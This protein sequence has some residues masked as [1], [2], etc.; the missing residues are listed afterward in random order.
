MKF[1]SQLSPDTSLRE[2]DRR[3]FLAWTASAALVGTIPRTSRAESNVDRI[4]VLTF[5]DAVKT[6]RTTVAPLLRELG[7]G[8]S[9]FVCHRWMVPGPDAY[10]DPDQYMTW[11]DIAELHQMGFEIGNHSWTHPSFSVP[12]DAAR[13]PA[14]LALV[15]FEL[16]KVGVP[17]PTSFA[18]CGDAFC[19]EAVQNL[20]DLGYKVAR[21]G[22]EPEVPFG[23]LTRTGPTYDPQ[24]QNPFL[25]PT[26][27]NN[28]PG[29][30]MDHFQ[31][32]ADQ[33]HPGQIVVYQFHGVPDPHPWVNCPP[34]RF[35]GYMQ[36]LKQAGFRVV[37]LKDVEQYLPTTFPADRVLK[38]PYLGS[39]AMK[40][41]LPTEMEATRADLEYWLTNMVHYHRYTWDE[42]EKVTGLPRDVLKARTRAI[43]TVG[44]SS[45]EA[46]G[47]EKPIRALP[48]PGGRHP[49]IGALEEAI[50]PLRGTKA[51][52]F[53]PWDPVS[54]VV[55]DLPEAISS[56]SGLI[57]QAHTYAPTI[58]D[59]QNIWLENIDWG[60]TPPGSLSTN[61][62]LPNKIAFGGLV[63][64]S[65]GAVDLELWLRN[66]S[67]EKLSSLSTRISLLLKGASDFDGLTN[68]NKVFQNPVSAVAS[69]RRDRW[70]LLAWDRSGRTW[71]DSRIPCIY[72]EVVLP[73]CNAG[74]VVRTHGRLWFYEG[75]DVT[76]EINRARQI[77]S[78]TTLSG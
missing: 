55:I 9:F 44:S 62:V 26:T 21:R 1:F 42:V 47:T 60:R 67:L 4:I 33:A 34:E 56:D 52:I 24:K 76:A 28:Y 14:E 7:F 75:N 8:A 63:Q 23:D 17:R 31:R 43:D 70:I 72:A 49:R 39:G 15:E 27:G 45:S 5:D 68:E 3:H 19:A 74:Q 40:L 36:Y 10:A 20:A 18:W 65:T 11:Q 57:F 2:I 73:E 22:T 64:E 53:L 51:S 38:T 41:V 59:D 78:P 46:G 29:W 66:D 61:R 69:I 13:L 12:R 71:G 35:R 48:Y 25:I 32:V 16:R 6:Q 30:N 54:Y 37:A 50:C 58:W 77:F